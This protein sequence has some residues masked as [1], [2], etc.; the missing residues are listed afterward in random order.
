MGGARFYGQKNRNSKGTEAE[1]ESGGNPVL[2]EKC[3]HK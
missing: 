3:R 2:E 1:K